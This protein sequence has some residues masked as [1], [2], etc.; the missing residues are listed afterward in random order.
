MTFSLTLGLILLPH[1]RHSRLSIMEGLDLVIHS[2][3]CNRKLDPLIT[4]I[5]ESLLDRSIT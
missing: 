2:I 5:P 4:E 1:M 3:L